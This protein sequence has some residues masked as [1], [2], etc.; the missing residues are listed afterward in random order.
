VIINS[1]SILARPSSILPRRAYS[2]GLALARIGGAH[3][4]GLL[5]AMPPRGSGKKTG[6]DGRH[7][8]VPTSRT[9]GRQRQAFGPGAGRHHVRCWI[10]TSRQ[11]QRRAIIGPRS[12]CGDSRA[13]GYRRRTRSSRA[14]TRHPRMLQATRRSR[15]Q[16][17][18]LPL[19]STS[20]HS[21]GRRAKVVRIAP[22]LRILRLPSA[23]ERALQHH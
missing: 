12:R 7:S 19:R 2:N 17:C 10:Q 18:R 21:C 1:A 8:C 4:A 11:E 5:P 9:V 22:P 13:R 15:R 20:V 23:V 6:R 14:S 3:T 16:L